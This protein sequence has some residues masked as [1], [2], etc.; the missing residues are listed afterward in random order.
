MSVDDNEIYVW[1]DSEEFRACENLAQ[2]ETPLKIA[3]SRLIDFYGMTERDADAYYKEA[4]E[5]TKPSK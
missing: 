2:Q 3:V 1:H 5:H 4:L